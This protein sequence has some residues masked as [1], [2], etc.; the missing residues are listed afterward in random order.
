MNT[1]PED[2]KAVVITEGEFDSM[3]I[4]E[5]TNM[6]AIS[7][8]FGANHLPLEVLPWLER[9][10]RIYLW[11]DSDEV[12]KAAAEKFADKLGLK[13]TLIVN[14]MKDDPKGPKDANDALREGRDL[15]QYKIGRAHV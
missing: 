9:F 3:A 2:A 14:T 1:V 6:A 8:P 7:L 12:G 10:E 15:L 13:R 5:A 4:Y 11:L